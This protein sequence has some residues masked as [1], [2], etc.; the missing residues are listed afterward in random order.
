MTYES[1]RNDGD[2]QYR[3]SRDNSKLMIYYQ[4][5]FKKK[6]YETYGFQVYDLTMKKLW[7][8]EYTLPYIDGLFGTD[9]VSVDD[10]GNAYVLGKLYKDKVK[11]RVKGKANYDFHIFAY[12]NAGKDTKEYTTAIEGKFITDISFTISD[13]GDIICAGFYSEKAG[14]GIRGCFYLAIDSKTKSVKTSNMKDFGIDFITQYM[15]ARQEKKAKK[16]EDKGEDQ[17]IYNYDL[18]N[19]VL[20]DDGGVIV[21]GEQYYIE[22]RTI[23]TMGANGSMSSRTV[24]YYHYNDVI[25]INIS[26]KGIIEWAQKIPKIQVT[27]EDGGFYSSYAMTVKDDKLYIIFNDSKDNYSLKPGASYKNFEMGKDAIVTMVTVDKSGNT[28][29]EAL[30]GHEDVEIITRPKVCEQ[31]S[32]NE[33]LIYG[34]KKKTHQFAK[35]T[36]LD[37]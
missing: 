12:K 4:L 20:R 35:L 21:V 26:P 31:I 5:P 32:A 28:K 17:E 29:R 15:S 9:K 23:T 22:A 30:F 7:Q 24:Y 36:F 6:D 37:K 2:F 11:E 19:M 13:S 3:M 34:Q 14:N 33:M 18:D 8:N 16:K 10:Q 1:K 25:V 27:A